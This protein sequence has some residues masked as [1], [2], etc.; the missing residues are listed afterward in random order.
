MKQT[1][2]TASIKRLL[3]HE[4]MVCITNATPLQTAMFKR[5]CRLGR[6]NA[7]EAREDEQVPGFTLYV[8]LHNHQQNVYVL[9]T[10]QEQPRAWRSLDALTAFLR[11]QTPARLRLNVSFK[12]PKGP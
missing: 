10:A 5:A 4:E 1:L 6:V 9:A 2:L 7:L 11:V 3:D 8:R 12:H